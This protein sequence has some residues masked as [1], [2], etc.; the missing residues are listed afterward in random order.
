MKA[1]PLGSLV[2]GLI[3]FIAMCFAVPLFDHI[4]PRILGIPFN[5]VWLTAWMV[6][7]PLCLY[8]AYRIEMGNEWREGKER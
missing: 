8:G 3:P 2:L 4:A 7:T 5:I 6:L 1:P